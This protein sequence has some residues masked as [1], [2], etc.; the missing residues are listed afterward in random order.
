MRSLSLMMAFFLTTFSAGALLAEEQ[1][2]Q[3]EDTYLPPAAY[4]AAPQSR[5]TDASLEPHHKQFRAAGHRHRE[6]HGYRERRFAG[7]KFPFSFF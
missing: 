3:D 6:A 1:Q 7:P 5:V 2:P 4:R